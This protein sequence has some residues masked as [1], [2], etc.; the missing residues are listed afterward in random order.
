MNTQWYS[1][2]R[3]SIKPKNNHIRRLRILA[4]G[5]FILLAVWYGL[6]QT[7]IATAQGP[8]AGNRPVEARLIKAATFTGD[9]RTLPRLVPVK[10]ERPEIEEPQANPVPLPG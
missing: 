9:L 2:Q 5:I 7:R 6:A 8:M 10:R 1:T 3:N 4:V